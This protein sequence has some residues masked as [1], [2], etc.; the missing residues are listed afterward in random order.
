M[1]ELLSGPFCSSPNPSPHRG[2][3]STETHRLW[4][5]IWSH[6]PG[7][8]WR[9][10]QQLE[11]LFGDLEQAWQASALSLEHALGGTR[12]SAKD[13]ERIEA[14]RQRVGPIPLS[15]PPT[16]QQRL[17]WSSRRCLLPTDTAFPT[18][19]SATEQPPLALY[20]QGRGSLWAPLRQRQ[21]IA[22]IGSRRPSRH[23]LTMARAVARALAEGGWPV[24][25]GLDEG[26]QAAAH[27]GCLSAGGRP[28]A[29]LGTPLDQSS[30]RALEPLQRHIAAEGLLISEWPQGTKARSGHFAL[31]RRLE[32]G[33]IQAVVL[34][35][36]PLQSTALKT[37]QLAWKQGLPI[38]VVPADA[39][40]SS[41]AG[42]NRLLGQ[43]AAPLL[44]PEEFSKQLGR[45]PL[46]KPSDRATPSRSAD[47]QGLDAA[48]LA[49][50]GRGASLEH[51]CRSLRQSPAG[52]S[53]R[54]LKLELAGL[55]CSA[56][57]LWWHPC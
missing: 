1:G 54:L 7:V 33:L 13:L 10:L 4:H 28:V 48:L 56:P 32:L 36:C 14:Y 51:L 42:S 55:V 47:G 6:C 17:Q 39:G 11:Q 21:A 35:E 46:P 40:R 45:G 50:L 43:G 37:A 15:H 49:A 53:Q 16:T 18:S 27:Q 23:G 9:R 8:G 41:A 57:G 5:L 22:V 26:I 29:V 30:P 20:W 3:G 19:L 12:M 31:R 52:V 24:L 44:L 25:A 34:I 38:W 2:V